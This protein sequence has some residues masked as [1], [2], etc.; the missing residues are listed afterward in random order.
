MIANTSANTANTSAPADAADAA[1]ADA[2]ADDGR[3]EVPAELRRILLDALAVRDQGMK[4]EAL[5][6]A[7]AALEARV[8]TFC[9][10]TPAYDPDRRLAKHITARRTICSRS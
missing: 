7:V 3:A 8:Q 10:R 4:D 5:A 6:K 1:D 9:A 2:D